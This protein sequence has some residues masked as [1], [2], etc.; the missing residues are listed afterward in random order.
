MSDSLRPLWTVAHQAPLSMGFSR[1]EYWSELPVPPPGSLPDP[2][3]KTASPVS[4]ALQ[5]DS[6]PTE[7]PSYCVAK[8]LFLFFR[9]KS[10]FPTYA[11]IFSPACV[12]LIFSYSYQCLFFFKTVQKSFSS[13][14]FSHSVI[15]DSLRPMDCSMPGP[16][17]ITNSQSLLKLMSIEL[18]MPSNHLI[19]CRRLLLQ[20]SIFASIRVFSNESALHIRWPKCW[21]FSFSISHSNE[22]SGLISFRMD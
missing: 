4:P 16:L 9:I 12:L 15:S 6:L 13:V 22:H 7:P 18:V 8:V 14:Q 3:T 11:K 21:R 10:F 5:A 20:P 19:L 1:R 17:S 2:G